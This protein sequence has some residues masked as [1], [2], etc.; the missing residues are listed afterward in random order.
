MCIRDRYN[1][2]PD[3]K[4]LPSHLYQIFQNLIE[5][6]IKYNESAVKSI[7]LS[8]SQAGDKVFLKVKDNGIGIEE[9][10]L[11]YIFE[12]FKKLHDS[13]QYKGTGLGLS[14]CKKIIEMYEGSIIAE[15]SSSGTTMTIALPKS[16][17]VV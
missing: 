16:L 5:N 4:L 8:H 12:P 13:S 3:L 15:S 17:V 10:Y 2:L 9:N 7:C 14:I 11:D 1:T 6:A